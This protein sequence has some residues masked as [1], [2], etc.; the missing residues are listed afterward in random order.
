[1]D[2]KPGFTTSEFWVTL[3]TNI[4]GIV[5]L[6]HPSAIAGQTQDTVTPILTQVAAF[7]AIIASTVSYIISRSNV[8]TAAAAAPAPTTAAK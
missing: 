6:I 1:M 7:L 3:L 2:V 5:F 8:K 4:V